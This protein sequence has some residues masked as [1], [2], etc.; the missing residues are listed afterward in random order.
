MN[1]YQTLATGENLPSSFKDALDQDGFA[2]IDCPFDPLWVRQMGK[3]YDRA[4]READASSVGVGSNTTRFSDLINGGEEFDPLYVYPPLLAACVHTLRQPFK[5]SSFLTRTLR[6]NSQSQNLHVDCAGDE[7]GWTMLGFIVMVDEFREENGGTCFV[8]G[9]HRQQPGASA[10]PASE[11]RA[12]SAC[13]AAGSML[14]YNGSV[15]HGHGANRTNSPRRSVQGAFVRRDA[16]AGY[17]FAKQM[18]PDTSDRLSAL[19]RWIVA[20]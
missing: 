3:A 7:R 8:P 6:P 16:P 19:A 4:V 15:L 10:I 1:W 11:Q 12:V 20:A 5:L 9:S 17:N 14:I 2:V 13:G 18:R